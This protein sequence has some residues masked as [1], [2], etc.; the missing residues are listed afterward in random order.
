M[1]QRSGQGKRSEWI[2]HFRA[3]P[4]HQRRN[5]NK[6][7]QGILC[8]DQKVSFPRDLFDLF[9]WPLPLAPF[10]CGWQTLCINQCSSSVTSWLHYSSSAVALSSLEAGRLEPLDSLPFDP[11]DLILPFV[12]KNWY[13]AP[14]E[15]APWGGRH[16]MVERPSRSSAPQGDSPLIGRWRNFHSVA[17]KFQFFF[18]KPLVE[19]L[20]SSTGLFTPK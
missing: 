16:L 12:I 6:F 7:N 1:A 14:A 13:Y 9:L 10:F 18:D 20:G 11:G 19:C 4:P 15:R 2:S 8:A 17:T 5:W 3:P